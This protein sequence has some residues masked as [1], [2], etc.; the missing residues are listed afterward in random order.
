MGSVEHQ[1]VT[2]TPAILEEGIPRVGVV[3][4]RAFQRARWDGR[5]VTWLGRRKTTGR[6][7]RAHVRP[8]RATPTGAR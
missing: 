1:E 5:I 3:V 7:T 2:S 4:S 6:F 8:N